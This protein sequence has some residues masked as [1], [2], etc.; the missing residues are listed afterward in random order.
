MPPHHGP[1]RPRPTH[2]WTDHAPHSARAVTTSHLSR[3]NK[4]GRSP[5]LQ[6]RDSTALVCARFVTGS[7]GC[8][9]ARGRAMPLLLAAPHHTP[10]RLVNPQSRFGTNVHGR[11]PGPQSGVAGALVRARFVT[12]SSAC[13]RARSRATHL[14][15]AA[16]HHAPHRSVN[17]QSRFRHERARSVALIAIWGCGRARLFEIR[18][19][20]FRVRS[21]LRPIRPDV[22]CGM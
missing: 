20:E 2:R 6:P 4:H 19:W 15:L 5:G 11:S 14:V 17:H 12:G 8:S 10:H 18:D 13:G 22:R 21:G 16:P 7:S 3:T 9:R 1:P